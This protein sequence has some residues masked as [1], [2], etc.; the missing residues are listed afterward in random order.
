MLA[1]PLCRSDVSDGFMR[2]RALS[3]PGEPMYIFLTS[4]LFLILIITA[5]ILASFFLT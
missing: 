1:V 2:S 5:L 3:S 4:I